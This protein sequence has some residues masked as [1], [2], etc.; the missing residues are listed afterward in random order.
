MGNDFL[1]RRNRQ[2]SNIEGS[3][4]KEIEPQRD[5]ELKTVLKKG[6]NGEMV[7]ESC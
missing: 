1:K 6:Q 3:R 5:M 2:V 4:R 7:T